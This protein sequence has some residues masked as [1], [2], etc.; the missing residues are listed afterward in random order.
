MN[1]YRALVAVMIGVALLPAHATATDEVLHRVRLVAPLSPMLRDIVTDEFPKD[2]ALQPYLDR[3]VSDLYPNDKRCRKP[4]GKFKGS[5]VPLNRN[6]DLGAII[7]VDGCGWG[8]TA[9]NPLLVF[10]KQDGKWRRA[11]E[12]SIASDFVYIVNVLRTTDHG[13]YRLDLGW[14]RDCEAHG[15]VI[16]TDGIMVWKGKTYERLYP[17]PEYDHAVLEAPLSPAL[18]LMVMAEF[19]K[20]PQ[21]KEYLVPKKREPPQII[22]RDYLARRFGRRKRVSVARL[23]S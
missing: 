14:E 15:H 5:I 13:Y 1:V 11:G 23:S 2:P 7:V 6:G 18:H 21:L 9:G 8:G 16:D 19:A 10:L 22:C 17:C 12:T 3:D 20:D 4:L